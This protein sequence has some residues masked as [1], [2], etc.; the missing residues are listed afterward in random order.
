MCV[1]VDEETR[2]SLPS[3]LYTFMIQYVI[4]LEPTWVS[5]ILCRSYALMDQE[6]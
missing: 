6:A 3:Y 4:H 5:S 1:C 2:P